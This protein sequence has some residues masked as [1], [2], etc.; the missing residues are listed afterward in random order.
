MHSAL[1]MLSLA[2][3]QAAKN[4]ATC[5]WYGTSNNYPKGCNNNALKDV[6]DLSVVFQPDG[7]SNCG[8]TGS[9][10]LFARTTHN[11]Q[12]CGVADLNGLM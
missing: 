6:D 4:Q 2:H 9:A 12:A 7:Y 10:S 5:A 11:G 8:K 1:A 3:G